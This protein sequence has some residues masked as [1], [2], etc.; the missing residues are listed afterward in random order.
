MEQKLLEE[1][2]SREIPLAGAMGV[3]VAASAGTATVLR[4]PL[5][6]NRNHLGTAFGGSLSTILI[7]ACYARLYGELVARNLPG[8]VVITEGHTEFLLPVGEDIEAVCP[9]PAGP[10]LE[11]F[12]EAFSRRGRGRL[13]LTATITTGAGLA[14]RF[15]GEFVAVAGN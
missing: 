5:G 12:I 13:N 10:D 11:Q 3:T 9:A 1:L 8:H 15:S 7:L 4:A 14:C 2:I 6:P